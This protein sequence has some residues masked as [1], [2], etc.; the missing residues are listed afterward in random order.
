M[1]FPCLFLLIWN[2]LYEI[3][4]W[5]CFCKSIH[6]CLSAFLNLGNWPLYSFGSQYM[7]A[8]S[9][10]YDFATWCLHNSINVW[11]QDRNES[12]IPVIDESTKPG[13]K[14]GMDLH[15]HAIELDIESW[16]VEHSMEQQD[17]DRPVK[18]QM[19]AYSSINVRYHVH[20][21]EQW[22]RCDNS[23]LGKVGA[24]WFFC[25]RNDSNRSFG[26]WSHC[27]EQSTR[28]C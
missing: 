9:L 19:P 15:H 24:R 5:G 16:P 23:W 1:W 6:I 12:E 8:N 11:S 28:I 4:M 17:E 22:F 14:G 10:A 26:Y 27:C 21:L 13:H 7:P 2:I 3:L 25:E 18:C 20:L